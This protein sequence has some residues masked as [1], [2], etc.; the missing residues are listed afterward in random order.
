MKRIKSKKESRQE[1]REQ[2]RT[3]LSKGGAVTKIPNGVSG[4]QENQNLFKYQ[5]EQQPKTSRTPVNEIV[6]E[7]EARKKQGKQNAD[8]K[9]QKVRPRKRLIVDDFGDPVRWV[10]EE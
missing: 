2:M 1:L 9:K 10:W 6:Q 8:R 5:G 7:I 3:F 4:N